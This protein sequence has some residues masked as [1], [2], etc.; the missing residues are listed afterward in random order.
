MYDKGFR[1]RRKPFF[2]VINDLSVIR[3]LFSELQEPFS[4]IVLW[5][6]ENM[7]KKLLQYISH[8]NALR[9]AELLSQIVA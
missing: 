1:V 7:L 9:Y 3:Q 2:I 5:E 4:G 8:M 6:R